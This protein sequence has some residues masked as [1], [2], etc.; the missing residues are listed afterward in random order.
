MLYFL[1]LSRNKLR[2]AEEDVS[3]DDKKVHFGGVQ[4]VA[5]T[6]EQQKKELKPRH[7]ILKTQG[8][9]GIA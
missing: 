9:G 7:S 8:T 5:K 3:G 2:F 6:N 4:N 1:V